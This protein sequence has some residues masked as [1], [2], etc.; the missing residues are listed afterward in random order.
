M[1]TNKKS[2]KY[3]II[4][5]KC[6]VKRHFLNK[7]FMIATRIIRFAEQPRTTEIQHDRSNRAERKKKEERTLAKSDTFSRARISPPN[8]TMRKRSPKA[9]LYSRLS[10]SAKN[11]SAK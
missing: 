5:I 2:L 11:I 3:S 1:Q 6:P 9:L 8:P 10:P 7:R 4:D